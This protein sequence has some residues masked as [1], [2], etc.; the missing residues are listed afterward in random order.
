MTFSITD[1]THKCR[2]TVE[3]ANVEEILEKIDGILGIKLSSIDKEET[4][5]RDI[6]WKA[7]DEEFAFAK[8]AAQMFTSY[9]GLYTFGD[10]V[11]GS[12]FAVRWGPNKN[13]VLVLKLD[14]F[15]VPANYTNIIEEGV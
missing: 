12:L 8:M 5:V 11:P 6:D 15:F 2:A 9:K 7:K 13:N 14:D 4:A 3:G 10:I 1:G